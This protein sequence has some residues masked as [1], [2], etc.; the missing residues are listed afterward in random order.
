[1]PK[2]VEILGIEASNSNRSCEVHKV[3]GI[4]VEQG[5]ILFTKPV[6]ILN[7]SGQNEYAIAATI[8]NNGVEEC[9]VGYVGREFHFFRQQYENKLLQVVECLKDSKNIEHR[10]RSHLS[11]GIAVCVLLN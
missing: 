8:L 2:Y 1:M 5:T 3:C 10:R 7:E 4:K 6:V 9:T 11:K